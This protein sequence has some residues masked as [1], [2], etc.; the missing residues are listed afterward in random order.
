MIRTIMVGTDLSP[1]AT[2]AVAWAGALARDCGAELIPVAALNRE[3]KAASHEAAS[4]LR[5]AVRMLIDDE[6]EGLGIADVSRSAVVTF[7]DARTL[8]PELIASEHVDLLVV[9]RT[10]AG[11]FTG[12]TFGGTAGFL[13]H[14]VEC[15]VAIVP[16]DIGAAAGKDWVLGVDGSEANRA[17][18]HWAVQVSEQVQSDVHAVHVYDPLIGPSSVQ[19]F[20]EDEAVGIEGRAARTLVDDVASTRPISF[21]RVDGHRIPGLVEAARRH[22]TRAIVVGAKGA[23]SLR[24]L[25]LG[26]VPSQ[27]MLHAECPVVIVKVG[28]AH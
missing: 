25:R 1:A 21:E 14:N 17:A 10:G 27:L 2:K 6:V 15:P 3:S 5:T 13:S 19:W 18:L 23:G 4:K 22:D 24:G 8:L 11:G 28:R 16:R 7:A 20:E 26:R 9:G 12:L